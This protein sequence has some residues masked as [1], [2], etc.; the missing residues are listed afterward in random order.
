M[1]TN[2]DQSERFRLIYVPGMKPKPPPPVHRQALWDALLWGLKR[3][4]PTLSE[5][6]KTQMKRFWIVSWTYL[7]YGVHRDFELDRPGIQALQ[8]H[9]DPSPA[10]IR[11]IDSLARRIDRWV[12][13]VGDTLPFLSRH[14][15]DED[16]RLTMAEARRYLGDRQGIGREVRLMLKNELTD[17][18][19]DGDRVMLIGHS[20]GSVIAYD[21]LWELSHE[22]PV[23]G[24]IDMF[25]T[26]GSPLATRFI[27][28]R[29]RGYNRSGVQRYPTIIRRWRNFSARAD[30]T[31]LH[32]SLVPYFGKMLDLNL[33]ESMEDRI[34]VLNH[35]RGDHGLNVHKSYG[36]LMNPGVASCIVDWLLECRPD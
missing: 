29:L 16:T 13:I 26:M 5:S 31:A 7:F 33:I 10:D 22:E 19:A 14:L 32:P 4:D 25:V 17:A 20:L 21:T 36:Y 18:W 23:A 6:L 24:R 28:H 11:E 30:L 1:S 9:P 12:R 2:R 34:N 8:T 27:R 3:V 35:F 15:A